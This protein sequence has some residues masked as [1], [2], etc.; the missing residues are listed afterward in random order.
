ME[1]ITKLYFSSQCISVYDNI[2]Q[3]SVFS[4]LE[5]VLSDIHT[6]APF[7]KISL[8]Y[9]K[10]CSELYKSEYCANLHDH[11]LSFVLSDEN[12]FT[13]AVSKGEDDK[14]PLQLKKAAIQDLTALYNLTKLDRETIVC[15]IRQIYP[16]FK[17]FLFFGHYEN[18]PKAFENFSVWSD[19]KEVKNSYRK[20]GIGQYAK[21]SAFYFSEDKKVIPIEKP[22]K[23]SIESLKYYEVQKQRVYENTKNFIEGK[24]ADNVLLYGD[25]GTGKSTLV[26]SMINCFDSLKIIEITKES[27]KDIHELINQIG[28]ISSKVI[29]FIDDLTFNENEGSFN[30]FKA[31]LEG[32]LSPLPKNMLIYATSN[33][34]HLIKET[35]SAREGNEL[36]SSDTRDESASLADRFGLTLTFMS[37]TLPEFL[38]MIT[39]MAKDRNL[40]VDKDELI[41][42][43]KAFSA[44]KG[45]RSGR[46]AKQYLDQL[47]AK[48]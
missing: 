4:S 46:V 41:K 11:I 10:L 30:T 6:K 39:E 40:N 34:R 5:N 15:E 19:G 20:N 24:S 23:V 44:R 7:E 28:K 13:K 29:V 43:A 32:S 47:E 22:R 21:Y 38:E 25:R 14:I 3:D 8:S 26:H 2:R 17:D 33:R 31:A 12:T 48:I 16:Q 9:S 1:F 35:F 36:H 45:N 37:P 18:K 42:G 27:I